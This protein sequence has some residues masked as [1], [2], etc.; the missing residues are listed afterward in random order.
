MTIQLFSRVPLRRSLARGGRRVAAGGFT[1][2]EVIVVIVLIGGILAIVG[3]KI[4][5]NKKSAEARLAVTQLQS[6]S[7]QIE[8]YQSDVGSYPESLQELV[9]SPSNAAGWLGPYAKA[10]DFNDPWHHPIEYR[11]PGDDDAP[12]KLVS[13]GADGKPGGEGVDKDVS[14]P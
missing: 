4:I 11:H 12:Y 6:L 10:T 13:L 7:A 8:Q 5:N 9:S 3:G 14:A 1:L 2:I